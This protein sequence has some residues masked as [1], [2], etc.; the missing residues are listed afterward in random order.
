MTA[1]VAITFVDAKMLDIALGQKDNFNS[2]GIRHEIIRIDDVRAYTTNLWLDLIDLTID[3]IHKHGKVM[4]LDAEVRIHRPL[5]QHWL[6]NG[7]VLFEPYPLIKEPFYT[8]INTGQI[9]F[10]ESGLEFLRILKECMLSMI[11][12]DDDTTL[13]SMGEGYHV[14]DELPSC[15]AIRLSKIKY[16]KERLKFER[17]LPLACAANRG[18]WLDE[19]TVLTHPAMHNW[20]WVGGGKFHRFDSIRDDVFLCHYDGDIIKGEF[21]IKMMKSGDGPMWAKITKEISRGI[22]EDGGWIFNPKDCTLAPKEFW[23]Q[24]PKKLVGM[25]RFS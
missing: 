25:I 24:Y 5:P 17:R 14:E 7:N 20:S 19:G 4:R 16:V 13:T 8:A 2:F 6:D 15:F 12:P 9:I 10:D 3:A 18:T 21:L 23:P 22:Y 11:P 1:P